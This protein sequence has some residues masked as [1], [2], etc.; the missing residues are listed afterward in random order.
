[1]TKM[2]GM[3]IYGKNPLRIFSARTVRQMTLKLG[4][5]QKG[6]EP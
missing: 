4:R 1:M 5:K 6:L 2:A 3:P